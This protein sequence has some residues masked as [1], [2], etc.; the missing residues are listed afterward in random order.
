[1]DVHMNPLLYQQ[2][3]MIS[4]MSKKKVVGIGEIVW[5]MF[6]DG[7]VLGGAPLNFAFVAG[8]LGCQPVIISAVGSAHTVNRAT[9]ARATAIWMSS[10]V[11]RAARTCWTPSRFDLHTQP[12]TSRARRP[13]ASAPGRGGGRPC[14]RFPGRGCRSCLGRCARSRSRR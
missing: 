9:S 3:E 11:I 10:A 1:M 6:P 12:D 14:G 2:K 8:E 5:D 7:S 4:N 13:F